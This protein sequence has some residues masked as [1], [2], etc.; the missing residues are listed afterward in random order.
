MPIKL[1]VFQ[2]GCR[3]C[4]FKRHHKC[5]LS[6]IDA[7]WG[8]ILQISLKSEATSATSIP[9]CA[10]AS[11]TWAVRGQHCTLC[12]LNNEPI[13]LVAL[14]S[15]APAACESAGVG[16][17][18]PFVQLRDNLLIDQCNHKSAVTR[19]QL[20][21]W[22]RCILMRVIPDN[23][24]TSPLT[25]TLTSTHAGLLKLHVFLLRVRTNNQWASAP[26]G[27]MLALIQCHSLRGQKE[28]E[29]IGFTLSPL[30]SSTLWTAATLTDFM[31]WKN[32]FQPFLNYILI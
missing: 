18:M 2:H 21:P 27:W 16:I 32:T 4:R 6:A 29:L 19:V 30:S 11:I 31:L 5:S 1:P 23:E 25:W 26:P 13:C 10:W 12:S 14:I 15:H 7:H 9:W 17:D 20:H 22:S 8:E 3:K 24:A 28:S